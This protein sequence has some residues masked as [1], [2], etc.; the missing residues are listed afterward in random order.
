MAV[1]SL[2]K[3]IHISTNNL[4]S[5]YCFIKKLGKIIKKKKYI[6]PVKDS[7]FKKQNEN[8]IKPKHLG[9][10]TKFVQCIDR[11]VISRRLINGLI[12]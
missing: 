5:M 8:I 10:K 12:K 6:F 1:F 9:L 2:K 4:T 3:I 11:T 7:Y